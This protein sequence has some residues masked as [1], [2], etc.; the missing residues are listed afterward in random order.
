MPLNSTMK[1][2]NIA[3]VVKGYSTVKLLMALEVL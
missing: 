1:N 3:R 2:H